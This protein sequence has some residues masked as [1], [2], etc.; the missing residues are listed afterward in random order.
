[1]VDT[2]IIFKISLT[3]LKLNKFN[4]FIN[5]ISDSFKKHIFLYWD[6]QSE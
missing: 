4:N 5:L 6:L 1:M 3:T 2:D